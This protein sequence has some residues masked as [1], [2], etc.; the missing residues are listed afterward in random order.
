MW[1]RGCNSCATFCC[2][3][4]NL[5]SNSI[6]LDSYIFKNVC[7]ARFYLITKFSQNTISEYP[8]GCTIW[9]SIIF[10]V[11]LLVWR[12]LA[13][14]RAV[15]LALTVISCPGATVLSM[16]RSKV[17]GML[18]FGNGAV[19]SCWT[20]TLPLMSK[21][22]VLLFYVRAHASLSGSCCLS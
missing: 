22:S 9:P 18:T 7:C 20:S 12:V 10:N 5:F 14:R 6:F 11:P 21:S 4:I 2:I 8:W 13:S 17:L 15:T 19:G 16:A 1:L 3:D